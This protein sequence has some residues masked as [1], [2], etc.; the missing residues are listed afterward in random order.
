VGT[1]GYALTFTT[2]EKVTRIYVSNKDISKQSVLQ[3]FFVTNNIES[4]MIAD[5][6]RVLRTNNFSESDPST[7][8]KSL[9]GV[10]LP[11]KHPVTRGQWKMW[12]IVINLND[13]Y[14]WTREA[15]A[16]WIENTFDIKDIA[17]DYK[18]V[19]DENPGLSEFTR[20]VTIER[21]L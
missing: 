8:A 13:Q 9:P 20:V 5:I 11:A 1:K 14:K 2:E 4:E 17:F 16:D 12:E 6:F 18:V 21:I 7:L 15:I 3:K 10:N 19:K